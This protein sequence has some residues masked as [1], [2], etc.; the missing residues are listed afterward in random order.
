LENQQTN[1]PQNE[2]QHKNKPNEENDGEKDNG[3]GKQA[4]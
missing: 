2:K 4:R 3:N 1:K